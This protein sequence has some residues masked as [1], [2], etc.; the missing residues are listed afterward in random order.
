MKE[1]RLEIKVKNNVVIKR[2]EEL[3]YESV[4]AFCRDKGQAYHVVNE[5]I[6]FK[7]PFYGKRGNISGSIIKLAE[8][9]SILPDHIYPPERREKP[10]LQNKYIVETEKADLMQIATGVRTDTLPLDD[11]KMLQDFAPT[12][13][14]V[15]DELTPRQKEVLDRRF[16]ITSG[17][18]ETLEEVGVAMGVC[19]QRVRQIEAK[20]MRRMKHPERSRNLRE[21][22]EFMNEMDVR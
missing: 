18:E 3:G 21:Y 13:H 4:P 17:Y 22:L 19:G 10:L 8:A 2:I 6:G 7:L 12:I 14:R 16:G 15:L 20:A 1:Y 11:R 9:L 5:I